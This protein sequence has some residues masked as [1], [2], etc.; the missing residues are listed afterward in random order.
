M[1]ELTLDLGLDHRQHLLGAPLALLQESIN[2]GLNI[3][4]LD[5]TDDAS[6]EF[7]RLGLRQF[8]QGETRIQKSPQNRIF[9]HFVK[10]IGTFKR[11]LS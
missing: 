9:I 1:L 11:F 7:F 3:L 10:R 4:R 2:L 6:N 5:I 8:G